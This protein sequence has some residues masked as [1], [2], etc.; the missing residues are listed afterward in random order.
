M[1]TSW[2]V[3]RTED[4]KMQVSSLTMIENPVATA[5]GLAGLGCQ[6][7]WPLFSERR[8]MLGVQMGIGSNYGVHYAMPD[9]WTAAGVC[10]L[11][12][13]QTL[14]AFVA[15]DRPWLT[16]L[17]LAFLP[18]VFGVAVLTWSGAASA[19]AL[20]ASTL[21]MLAR[22]QADTLRL[23]ALMLA[24]CPFGMAH[25]LTIGAAPAFAGALISFTVA[26]LAFRREWR[27]AR[28]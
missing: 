18:V 17:G 2:Y 25:D 15:G 26:A 24:S 1:Q 16:R 27:A 22:L 19:F 20:M 14:V 10:T 13:T 21:I 3:T 11:G 4:L 9:A 28:A 8:T 5:F 23:R 7:V 12:A 6:L